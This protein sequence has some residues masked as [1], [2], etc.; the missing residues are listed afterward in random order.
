[1]SWN[2]RSRRLRAALAALL[3]HDHA[4]E[5]RRMHGWLDRGA[6]LTLAMRDL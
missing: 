2:A 1:M 4:A 3:V 6:T 5:L